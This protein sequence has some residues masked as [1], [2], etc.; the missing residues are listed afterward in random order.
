MKDMVNWYVKD[1]L[2]NYLDFGKQPRHDCWN[3]RLSG[4]KKKKKKIFP[5]DQLRDTGTILCGII[6]ILFKR[7]A[8]RIKM[9]FADRSCWYY[10]IIRDEDCCIHPCQGNFKYENLNEAGKRRE[11]VF[12]NEKYLRE[13]NHFKQLA[14]SGSSST[15]SSPIQ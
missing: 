2:I 10:K 14:S 13:K 7:M 8:W 4:K 3:S 6:L 11:Y 12:L 15:S 5:M 9:V 1:R